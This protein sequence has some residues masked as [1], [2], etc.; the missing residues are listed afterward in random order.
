MNYRDQLN[1][2][3]RQVYADLRAI[4][5]DRPAALEAIDRME[6]I[7]SAE[8]PID[9]RKGNTPWYVGVALLIIVTLLGAAINQLR[10]RIEKA[11]REATEAIFLHTEMEHD[12]L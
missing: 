8:L 5:C 4:N 7:D 10:W 1:E 6:A 11:E 12:P 2:L 9:T 3:R